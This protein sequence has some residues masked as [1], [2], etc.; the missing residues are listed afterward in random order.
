MPIFSEWFEFITGKPPF[1]Y[2]QQLATAVEMPIVLDVFTGAGK[3]AA[4]VM[5]WFWRRR[6]AGLSVRT[7]TPRRLIYVLPMRTLVEQTHTT[8]Q[9]WCEREAAWRQQEGLPERS[10]ELHMLMSG[11]VNNRW[12]ANPERD[13]ILVGTQD[14][15]LSRGL[16][17]GYSMS[18]Y[19]WVIHFAL[20]NND[21]LWVVDE[22]QLM[23]AGLK[24]TTQLQGFREYFGTYGPS[25]SLWMS[26]TLNPEMLRTVD[27][28]HALDGSGKI[29]R[30]TDED[31][32]N[33]NLRQRRQARKRLEQAKVVCSGKKKDETTYAQALAAEIAQVHR[34]GSLTLVICNQVS[35]AQAVYEALQPFF[36]Q[37]RFLIHSRFRPAEREALNKRIL[38]RQNPLLGVL[39]ATQ[40]IEAGIDISALNLFSELAPWA[41]LVQRIGRCNRYGLDEGATVYWIDLDSRTDEAIRPYSLAELDQA[42]HLLKRVAEESGEVGPQALDKFQKEFKKEFQEEFKQPFT[43]ELESLIPRKHD[44]LQLFD[45]STDLAGHDIDIS[46]F[47]R[48]TEDTDIAIAW[49]D[50][51]GN[52]PPIGASSQHYKGALQA[53][54]L[55]RVSI[56]RAREFLKQRTAWTFDRLQN[57]WRSV[58]SD[59]IFPSMLLLLK[60]DSGGYSEELGFT[61]NPITRPL[62]VALERVIEPDHNDSDLLSYGARQF[63][64]LREHSEAIVKKATDLCQAL[65]AESQGLDL[66]ISKILRAARWHD[67]GKG[68]PEFQKMLTHNRPDKVGQDIWAKSDHAP[69][70]NQADRYALPVD[71]RGFRHE[72]VSALLA[73]QEGEEFLVA[74]LAACHHGKVRLTIQPRPTEQAPTPRETTKDKVQNFIKIKSKLPEAENHRRYALGVHEGDKVSGEPFNV[75][76]LGD[77]LAIACPP[78]GLSLACMELGGEGASWTAQA[79]NLLEDYGP[80]RLAFL[81]TLIRLADWRASGDVITSDRHSNPLENSD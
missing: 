73:L 35:R 53:Q 38:D 4:I 11:A 7:Q 27:Y 72:L 19:R 47:I 63:I 71:R 32:N 51:E 62:P 31:L 78:Q 16:N 13:C 34:P 80:F 42:R 15:I 1:F 23:G 9:E 18:R 65:Q 59:E 52:E 57:I 26:A 60:C 17:R 58:R 41:S 2:Q 76:D 69:R 54:E 30:L 40:A 20:L 44:L 46:C 29:L 39:V 6:Y 66:P 49:R 67:A 79:L 36:G 56:W 68:H 55:C 12:D 8:I 61:G 81:E 22:T 25:R 77:G 37:E 64:S 74:Y 45:T 14:Q 75:I 3:T 70:Q 28:S 33:P 24:T 10:L 48:D 43:P 50:W 5:A 21:S